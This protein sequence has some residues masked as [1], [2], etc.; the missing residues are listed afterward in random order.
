MQARCPGCT[1]TLTAGEYMLSKGSPAVSADPSQARGFGFYTCPVCGTLSA[2]PRVVFH[3]WAQIA[4]AIVGI[5]LM[6][7]WVWLGLAVGYGAAVAHRPRLV[8]VAGRD[9]S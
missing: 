9:R 5:T 8:R 6:P 7:P 4:L 2:K 1:H 3:I